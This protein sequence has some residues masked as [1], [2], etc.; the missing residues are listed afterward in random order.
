MPASVPITK[1][2]KSPCAAQGSTAVCSRC[3]QPAPGYDVD[4]RKGT[5]ASFLGVL[6]FL[7]YAMRRVSGI[8]A[9]AWIRALVVC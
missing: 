8:S 1:A 4:S 7:L 6:I 2:L 3:H 5:N 9:A